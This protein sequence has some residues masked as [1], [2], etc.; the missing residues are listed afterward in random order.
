MDKEG[1]FWCSV[2]GILGILL[3]GATLA[4]QSCYYKEM[5][6]ELSLVEQGV[7]L[8]E[9]RCSTQSEMEEAGCMAYALGA[10]E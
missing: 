5:E 6:H 9:I 7:H 3:I 8:M 10:P 4:I 2:W 1:K